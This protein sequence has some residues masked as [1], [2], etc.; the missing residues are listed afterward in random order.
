ML[1]NGE[2]IVTLCFQNGNEESR[3]GSKYVEFL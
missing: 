2:I 1:I 3:T